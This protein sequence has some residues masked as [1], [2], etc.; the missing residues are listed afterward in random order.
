LELTRHVFWKRRYIGN[1][2]GWSIESLH[3]QFSGHDRPDR[4]NYQMSNIGINELL[5]G[6]NGTLR[7][8]WDAGGKEDNAREKNTNHFLPPACS[9]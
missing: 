3:C 6:G 8:R 9:I 5:I 2:T 7:D 1:R 4:G